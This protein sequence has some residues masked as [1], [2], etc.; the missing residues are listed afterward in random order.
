MDILHRERIDDIPL[1]ISLAK[2]L[3]IDTIIAAHLQRH[4]NMSGIG[5]GELAIGWLSFILSQANHRKSHVEKW[6]RDREMT[7]KAMI[8]SRIRYQDFSDDRLTNLL[9]R[10]NDDDL[11]HSIEECIWKAKIDVFEFPIESVR[12]DSTS[13]YGYHE[14]LN[15]GLMKHGFSKD[16]KSH[17]PQLKLMG[18]IEGTHGDLIAVDVVPGNINDDKLYLPLIA[19]I[20]RIIKKKGLLYCGD[21]KMSSLEIRGN[22]ARD[23]N[24]YLTPLQKFSWC[25][26]DFDNWLKE[27]IEGKQEANLLWDR[28]KLLGGGYEFLRTEMIEIK[29]CTYRWLERVIVFRSLILAQTQIDGLEKRIKRAEE[30]IRSLG[31]VGKSK[32]P[33]DLERLLQKT[34]EIL[35]KKQVTDMLSVTWKSIE[36]EQEYQRTEI[37]G[38]KRRKGSYKV[39][40][41]NF[42]LESL[43]RNQEAIQNAHNWF[44]WRIYVTNAQKEKLNMEDAMQFYRESWRIERLFHFLKSHPIEIQPL[45]VR[46]DKQ[47]VGLCRLLTLGMRIWTH[48][49][50]LVQE[51]LLENNMCIDRIYKGQP[52]KKTRTPSGNLILGA[53]ENI[54][55]LKTRRGW[56]LT[57]LEKNAEFFLSFLG[58]KNA[59]EDMLKQVFEISPRQSE[60]CNV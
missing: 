37:R 17:L 52:R 35:E 30:E 19:R 8:S 28:E 1:I 56:I 26:D 32:K 27:V 29:S 51:R 22:I 20:K 12:L 5:Y 49:E 3:R 38:G 34:Q 41:I 6:A 25:A 2:Q 18:G 43:R 39:T 23:G 59:Y 33:Q 42:E 48:M 57:P 21:C 50:S 7:L 9:K 58:I 40:K 47:L 45:F 16:D 14:V 44:G 4:G 60:K 54:D 15:S 36:R 55:L 24:F 10:L 11:W 31:K 13:T 46:N 53:F